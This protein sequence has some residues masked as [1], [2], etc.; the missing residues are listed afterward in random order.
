MGNWIASNWASVAS[1]VIVLLTQII[2]LARTIFTVAHHEK[3]L[4]RLELLIEAHIS[5]N[6]LHR[7]PDFEKRLDEFSL[8]LKEIKHNVERLLHQKE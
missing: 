5:S 3:K 8:L 1:I 2:V 6:T 4:E 7:T